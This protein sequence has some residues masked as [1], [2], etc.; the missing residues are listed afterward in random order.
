MNNFVFSSPGAAVK[1]IFSKPMITTLGCSLGVLGVSVLARAICSA[2]DQKQL[3][4]YA[5][6][7]YMFGSS[8][9]FIVN[10]VMGSIIAAALF[11]LAAGIFSA[12]SAILRNE[13]IENATGMM[14]ISSVTALVITAIYIVIAFASVGVLNHTQISEA[15]LVSASANSLFTAAFFL[16]AVTIAAEISLIRLSGSI[17][18]NIGS[19]D[20]VKKGSALLSVSSIAGASVAFGIFCAALYTLVIPSESYRQSIIKDLPVKALEPSKII[21]D[22]I[23]IVLY[24]SLLVMFISLVMIAFSYAA[25]MD[26]IKRAA[27]AFAYNQ[28]HMANDP[29]NIPDYAAQGNY[30]YN[31]QKTYTPYF[32]MNRQYQDV[33]R[34]I[35]NGEVTP[36]PEPPVNPFKPAPAS[37]PRTQYPTQQHV[38][39]VQP[40]TQNTEKAEAP[41]TPSEE[42]AS[43]EE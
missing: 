22:S 14:K 12:R 40:E 15:S 9:V 20:T 34:N 39:P 24:I 31:Q 38:Q 3:D 21:M 11:F 1:N 6:L 5:S 32:D 33:Y 37:M 29:N 41:N 25:A 19:S 27:R 30:N 23:N 42:K 13:T 43:S 18:K 4:L 2:A 28:M 8:S 16:G 10:I 7:Y 26:S 35:Y 17:N 36:T